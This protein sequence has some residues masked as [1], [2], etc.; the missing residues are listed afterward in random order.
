M[1][2]PADSVNGALPFRVGAFEGYGHWVNHQSEGDYAV[3]YAITDLGN[4]V[5]HHAV[6]REFLKPDGSTLYVEETTVVFTPEARNRLAVV[7]TGPKGS[8]N[9]R[10]YV[11]GNQ[12]HYDAD[13]APGTTLEFTFTVV[14]SRRIDGLASSTN[15]GSMTCWREQL[16]WVAP[17]PQEY[18]WD[19]QG[20]D[21]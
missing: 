4:G 16:S 19:F 2:L 20:S 11:F 8:V 17:P 6:R 14:D 9:G 12:C 5:A 21:G 15:G 7:I 13:I 3:R 10:G 1:T 18:T